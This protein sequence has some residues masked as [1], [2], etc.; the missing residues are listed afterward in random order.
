M[1]DMKRL[2]THISIW[3]LAGAMQAWG[4]T[5]ETPAA[6]TTA[7]ERISPGP[8]IDVEQQI[9]A[10]NAWKWLKLFDGEINDNAKYFIIVRTGTDSPEDYMEMP[11]LLRQMNTLYPKMQR[12]NVEMLFIGRGDEELLQ[13][14]LEKA[15]ALFPSCYDDARGAGA[16]AG[17]RCGPRKGMTIVDPAGNTVVEV[18][19]TRL[20][21][22]WRFLIQRWEA[23]CA[24]GN[25]PEE[26][27]KESQKAFPP[28]IRELRKQVKFGNVHSEEDKDT[29]DEEEREKVDHGINRIASFLKELDDKQSS[30]VS[31]RAQYFMFVWFDIAP[32]PTDPGVLKCPNLTKFV[33]QEKEMLKEIAHSKLEPIVQTVF[34]TKTEESAA[35]LVNRIGERY[36]IYNVETHKNVTKLYPVATAMN[37]DFNDFV[38]LAVARATDSRVIAEG[39]IAVF[40][41]MDLILTTEDVK[42]KKK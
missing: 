26:L 39:R 27:K 2:L 33:A 5:N 37:H 31:D 25:D 19:G 6:G 28:E 4:G 22:H 11:E 30:R 40:H 7:A 9:L 35:E 17:Y 13:K 20:L 29:L 12:E 1:S 8:M 16:I 42:L 21:R 14:T 24:V 18:E 38:T 15:K 23:M 32:N 36:P 3:V 41:D 10:M 34:V